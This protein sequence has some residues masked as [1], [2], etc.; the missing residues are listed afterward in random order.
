MESGKG[1]RGPKGKAKTVYTTQT[2]V[3][4]REV[5][6]S[7]LY[8]KSIPTAAKTATAMPACPPTLS[9]PE[10]ELEEDEGEADETARE[11]ADAMTEGEEDEVVAAAA[12]MRTEVV[13]PAEADE[14]ALGWG[15]IRV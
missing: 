2:D 10:V 14:A 15:E 7:G 4:L 6:D 9:A 11:A 8:A 13:R 12:A 1:P 3:L 5:P